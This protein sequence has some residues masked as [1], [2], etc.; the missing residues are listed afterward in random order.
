MIYNDPPRDIRWAKKKLGKKT[1]EVK[2]MNA[3]IFGDF[4][5]GKSIDS[6]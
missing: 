4:I 1:K 3:R 6:V 2:V 5:V